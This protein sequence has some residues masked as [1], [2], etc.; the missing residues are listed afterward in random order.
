MSNE[1]INTLPFVACLCPTYRRPALLANAVA[2]FEAQ[3]YPADRRLLWIA[4]DAAQIPNGRFDW[5]GVFRSAIRFESLPIKY[6]WIAGLAALTIELPPPDIYM[7]WEDDDVYLPHHISSH[8]AALATPVKSAEWAAWEIHNCHPNASPTTTTPIAKRWSK[9][10]RVLST[11]HVQ[12]LSENAA[13]RFFAS[14]AV[15]RSL[16]D[17]CG[18]IVAT[19]RADFDQ[20]SLARF[21]AIGGPPAD[22]LEHSPNATPGY[23]FRFGTTQAYHGQSEMRS[24]DDETWY[25][26]CR[27]SGDATPVER[28]TPKMDEETERLYRQFAAQS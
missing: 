5:G 28:L 21:A 13:G 12:P 9:P 15:T 22:P 1:L 2:C 6:N 3:D 25:D 24:A 11:Y 23:C 19:K 27:D 26:R 20:Q 10:S 18:G 4:D 14:I 7:I 16:W 8:V 17:E